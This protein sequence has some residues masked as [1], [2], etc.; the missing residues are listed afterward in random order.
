ML[1]IIGNKFSLYYV[2][3]LLPND[4]LRLLYLVLVRNGNQSYLYVT[5]A[6]RIKRHAKSEEYD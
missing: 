4:S 5:P 2:P 6:K 1:S 3:G